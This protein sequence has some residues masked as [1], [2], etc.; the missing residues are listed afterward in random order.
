MN[1]NWTQTN[2]EQH[3]ILSL[4]LDQMNYW[5]KCTCKIPHIST[6][7]IVLLLLCSY[8]HFKPFSSVSSGSCI[9][10]AGRPR[11]HPLFSL[12]GVYLS[13]SRSRTQLLPVRRPCQV[14][15]S[16]N[17][18]FPPSSPLPP[19]LSITVSNFHTVEMIT[20]RFTFPQW[21]CLCFLALL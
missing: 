15:P 5:C 2:V 6:V 11:L 1:S 17:P 19:S 18:P 16:P 10:L 21:P 3:I 7:L 4:F 13:I 20:Q 8:N 14:C 12:C 9:Q